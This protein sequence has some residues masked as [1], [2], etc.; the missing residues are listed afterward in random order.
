MEK[1]R[2]AKQSDIDKLERLLNE[3]SAREFD[4]QLQKESARQPQAFRS[5][6]LHYG[7]FGKRNDEQPIDETM[8]GEEDIETNE[9]SRP[10]NDLYL[11]QLERLREK[12]VQDR[13]FISKRLLGAAKEKVN[14]KS[15]IVIG[16]ATTVVVGWWCTQPDVWRMV[17]SALNAN[18][19]HSDLLGSPDEVSVYPSN[20]KLTAPKS[21]ITGIVD[22]ETL[23]ASFYW[24]FVLRNPESRDGEAITELVIPKGSAVSRA[25]LWVNGVAQE[26]AFSST[27]NVTT[28]YNWVRNG[29]RDPLLVTWLD[30]N[31]VQIKASPVPANGRMQI[32]LGITSPLSLT[33]SGECTVAVPHIEKSNFEITGM[34]DLHLE[35]SS[36]IAAVGQE[37]KVDSSRSNY[38]LRANIPAS[39]L[40][41]ITIA[42]A[43]NTAVSKFATR[44]THAPNGTYIVATLNE[45]VSSEIA[46]TYQYTSQIPN[47]PIIDSEDAAH[48]VSNLWARNEIERLCAINDY[49]SAEDL[50][51]VYRLVSERTGATVLER[52]SDYDR[53]SLN[54]DQ[55][56]TVSYQQPQL[57]GA[58]NGFIDDKTVV[59]GT[60]KPAQPV[61]N[62]PIST[63]LSASSRDA[64]LFDGPAVPMFSPPPLIAISMLAASLGF[65]AL[66]LAKWRRL[67]LGQK[68]CLLTISCGVIS[69]LIVAGIL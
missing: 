53:Y 41:Q 58:T 60:R 36:K 54:R 42:A 12:Q 7:R 61:W 9:S 18:N 14:L 52:Q 55:F 68:S 56:G 16:V 51:S 15:G 5:R 31:R 30:D 22:T 20:L 24:T 49:K 43:R 4:E 10:A 21:T 23:T 39:D 38:I 11:R 48:R 45:S 3:P 34:Q 47:V 67:S 40:Q 17:T 26:A 57:S 6:R 8:R 29:R 59:F 66:I 33:R 69:T 19:A 13:R 1:R 2:S 37:F 65:F 35:S 63:W 64:N 62:G 50:G 32:R 44:A 27:N 28:A 46:A 25:T